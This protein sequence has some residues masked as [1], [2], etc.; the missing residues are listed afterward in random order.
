MRKEN[1]RPLKMLDIDN[2]SK[3]PFMGSNCKIFDKKH[4]RIDTLFTDTSGFGR[5][6]ELA[7]TVEGFKRRMTNLIKEYGCVYAGF[8]AIGQFQGYIA[9]WS[10]DKPDGNEIAE[11]NA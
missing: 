6:Y 3:I 8:E 7:Y 11:N 9:V 1:K 2:F 4:K 10:K 5:E